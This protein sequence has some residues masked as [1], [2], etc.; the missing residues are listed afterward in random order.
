MDMSS[1]SQAVG[2]KH[3]GSVAN[4]LGTV[5]RFAGFSVNIQHEAPPSTSL[6]IANLNRFLLGCDALDV[7]AKVRHTLTDVR[8]CQY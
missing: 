6:A 7:V 2:K 4:P 8:R 5:P 3:Y 1:T